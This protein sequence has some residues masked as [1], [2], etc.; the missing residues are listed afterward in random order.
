VNV[1]EYRARVVLIRRKA[2]RNI[3][4]NGRDGELSQDSEIFL[5]WL[6]RECYGD[7]PTLVRDSAGRIDPIASAYNE[8]ARKIWLG[9][10]QALH[11]P[12]DKLL[13]MIDASDTVRME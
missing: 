2:V 12:D 1:N 3:L 11:L 7:R 9:V 4:L 13:A 8:G 6:R 10:Q 5:S